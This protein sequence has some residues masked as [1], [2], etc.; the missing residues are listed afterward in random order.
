[1]SFA[2][3]VND[4]AGAIRD[5]INLMVPRL[6][7]SGGTSGQVLAKTSAADYAAGW[8]DAA[9]GG[10]LSDGN[11]GDVTVSGSGSVIS[12]NDEIK[13]GRSIAMGQGCFFN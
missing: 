5:K 7:P 6:L 4:L 10:G 8:V 11:K 3:R 9:S 13:Y 2:S 12:I 1:M